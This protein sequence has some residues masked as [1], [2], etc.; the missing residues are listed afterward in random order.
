VVAVADGHEEDVPQIV[1]GHAVLV[2][3]YVLS[4]GSAIAEL[5]AG[6]AVLVADE[7]MIFLVVVAGYGG[8]F[9]KIDSS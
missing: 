9:L 2:E 3:N 4:A 8:D 6:A 7:E 1:C 5:V